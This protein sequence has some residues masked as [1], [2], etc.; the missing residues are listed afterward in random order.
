MFTYFLSHFQPSFKS[1]HVSSYIL[2]NNQRYSYVS[3][4][5]L[6]HFNF[7]FIL[8]EFTNCGLLAKL[9]VTRTHRTC[10]IL[11]NNLSCSVIDTVT[12]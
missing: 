5:Y 8:V 4:I 12:L 1:I 9:K 2:K 6:V 11:E 7:F 10:H 3:T